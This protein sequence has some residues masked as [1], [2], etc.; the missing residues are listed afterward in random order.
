MTETSE[1][2]RLR[3]DEGCLAAHA[4]N[5]IGDRWALLVVRE[6]IFAPK[7]F[8]ALRAGLPGITAGVLSNRLAQLAAAGLVRPMPGAASYALTPAGQAL[9]PVLQSLC[10]WGAALPGHDPRRFISPS[11]LMI[12][13]TAMIDMDRARGEGPGGHSL[14]AG[15]DMGQEC[16][17]LVLPDAGAPEVRAAETPHGDFVLAGSG[18]LL[19]L[20]LYGTQPLTAL[21]GAGRIG[22][23]GDA[24]RA[25]RFAD[26]LALRR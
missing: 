25:Q 22:L 5:L 13:I 10:R 12:S 6:M 23:R 9:L 8:M 16:F 26:L 24:A 3:Y 18:N 17:M 15:F 2:P 7:R 20:A 4:L 19:A 11:A 14:V 1:D 21:A